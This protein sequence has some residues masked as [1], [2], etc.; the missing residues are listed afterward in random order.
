MIVNSEAVHETPRASATLV[1]LRDSP[2]H[3]LEVFLLRRHAASAVLGGVFVFA[4]GKLDAADCQAEW[5]SHLNVPVN[6]LHQ[7]LGE[8]QLDPLQ[9]SGLYVAALREALEECGVLLAHARDAELVNSLPQQRKQLQQDLHD[10]HDF[11]Q[12]VAREKLS[13]DAAALVPWSRWITPLIP[14]VSNKR[15]DTRF[16]LAALPQGQEP[17]H[18]NVEAVESVWLT[19]RQALQSYCD[20]SIS[21]AP[22][23]IMSL[24]NLLPFANVQSALQ[25]ARLQLPPVV[26]PE[27]FDDQ[28]VRTIC[29]PGD[30]RHSVQQRALLV[31]TRLRFV[32]GRFEP[33]GGLQAFFA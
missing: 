5:V 4:G 14:S 23:Q 30:P 12:L 1:L 26:L 19:P 13:L 9:A 21:L 16:F 32:N 18:D 22:P 33:L 17:V 31:P 24:V 10:G 3:E 7:R 15:F 27:T 11:A 8:P 29:Y 6:V 2:R 28:G 25:S 20:H